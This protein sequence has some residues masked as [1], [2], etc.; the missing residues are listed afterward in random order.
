MKISKIE[1]QKKNKHRFNLYADDAYLFSV[2]EDT[3]VHFHLQ[4]GKNYSDAE[5]ETIQTYE[6][7]MR[8]LSQ[9][10]RYLSRRPHLISELRVKLRQKEFDVHSI[11]TVIDLLRDKKY[12]D[13]A[14]FIRRFIKDQVQLKQTGPLKIRQKLL[15][16]GAEATT[17]D[18]LLTE[19]YPFETQLKNARRLYEKR[20]QRSDAPDQQKL[21][22][23][24]QQK[25]YS[26]EV[27]NQLKIKNYEL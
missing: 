25:G 6:A 23:H 4:K 5:L 27:I 14:D 22:R 7:H 9:A 15:Q 8:C 26:W 10:Y 16:K 13:D 21:I 18:M 17:T 24:L 3:L 11:D 2:S 12:L 20:K 19:L 1:I